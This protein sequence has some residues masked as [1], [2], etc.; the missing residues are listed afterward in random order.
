MDVFFKSKISQKSL[1]YT[2]D[3][4]P[5]KQQN[6]LYYRG[7]EKKKSIFRGH[8]VKEQWVWGGLNLNLNLNLW[9]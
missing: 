5:K 6:Y 1:K 2:L 9:I 3:Y 4:R 7:D 8:I